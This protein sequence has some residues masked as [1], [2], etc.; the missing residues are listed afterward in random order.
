MAT[1]AARTS[2]AWERGQIASLLT[3]ATWCRSARSGC[4]DRGGAD[5]AHVDEKP[6]RMS[7][8]EAPRLLQVNQPGH[9]LPGL[10]A[11]R[12]GWH[13][14]ADT[15]G[16]GEPAGRRPAAQ[17]VAA[18]GWQHTGSHVQPAAQG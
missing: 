1:G 3:A 17:G 6:P 10:D 11:G 18:A 14:G 7:G 16:G 12:G 13:T 2:S 15:A 9:A 4:G 8:K 5:R